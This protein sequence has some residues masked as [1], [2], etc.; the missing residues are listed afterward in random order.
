MMK[1]LNQPFHLVTVS[2]WPLLSSISILLMLFSFILFFM[3]IKNNIMILSLICT[4]MCLIQWW[5]DVIRE[6]TFQGYHN[7]KVYSMIKMG[8]L[9]FIV[10]ELMFFFS[11]FWCYF[12]MSLSP[13]IEIGSS[14]WPP[15][16]IKA[17][18]PYMIPL[19]NTMILLSSGITVTYCHNSIINNLK[20]ESFLSLLITVILGIIFTLFQYKEYNDSTFTLCD[21]VYGSIFFLATGFHGFHVIMGT[22]FLIVNLYRIYYSH[23][24]YNHHFGFEAAA[25]YWHFVDM[26]WLF[27]YLFVYYWF[28]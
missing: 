6:S 5:R 16:N 27:L 23:F 21:S 26:V 20:F 11:I 9:L 22:T 8:M 15:N 12:H 10:S 18:N 7:K 2:P 24:S 25:W 13:D 14:L 28:Y 1:K 4:M 19:L 17:F 3:K